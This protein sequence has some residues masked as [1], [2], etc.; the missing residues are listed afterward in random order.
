M[1]DA[2]RT[3]PSLLA[4]IELIDPLVDSVRDEGDAAMCALRDAI[5]DESDQVTAIDFATGKKVASV[6]VG[7]HPQRVRLG[8][9]EAGWTSPSA[10]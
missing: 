2:V 6:P 4:A 7:D 1:L 9:V 10:S 8:H 3:A 5:E